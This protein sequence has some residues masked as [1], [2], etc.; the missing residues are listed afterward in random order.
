MDAQE[1]LDVIEKMK[2]L[3]LSGGPA[4]VKALMAPNY[5]HWTQGT[6]RGIGE[7]TEKNIDRLVEYIFSQVIGEFKLEVVGITAEGDRIAVEAVSNA[8][9]RGGF[10]YNNKYHLLFTIRD[11]Y[12]QSFREYLDTQHLA[13]VLAH[14]EAVTGKPI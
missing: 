7:I 1:N 10:E 3:L 13:E 4:A 12:I 14:I 8:M 9:I 5:T 11:G 2:K 6:Y